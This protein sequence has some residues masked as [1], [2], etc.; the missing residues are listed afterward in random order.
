[1][2]KNKEDLALKT[3][4]LLEKN[5]FNS[6]NIIKLLKK[7]KTR[8]I[9]NK[10]DLLTNIN[11]YFDF[12][13]NNNLQFVEKS[14]SKDMLFEII[15]AK[16]DVMNIH[17]KSV[18]NLL[19]NF[20]SHPKEFLGFLPTFIDSIILIATLSNIN[21]SGLN[22]IPKIK[23]ISILFILILF[24]WHSDESDSLEKTMYNLDKYLNQIEKFVKIN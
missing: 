23:G 4:K 16:L 14:S 22:G 3:L 20:R 21:I 6:S 7:N 13:L 8:E 24:T 5:S 11:K 10:K 17:R 9:K 19:K 12:Q 15:M 18:K 2:N 1:M